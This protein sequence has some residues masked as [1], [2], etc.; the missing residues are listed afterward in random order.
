MCTGIVGIDFPYFISSPPAVKP[1]LASCPEIPRRARTAMRSFST[2][3][4]TMTHHY[5][6]SVW[7]GIFKVCQHINR[8]PTAMTIESLGLASANE[9]PETKQPHQCRLLLFSQRPTFSS[10]PFSSSSSV[11]VLQHR[12]R[13][14]CRSRCRQQ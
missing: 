1:L 5:E 2:C 14:R 10:C 7:Y 4:N 3:V 9:F 6:S 8:Q 13:C 11:V 12:R